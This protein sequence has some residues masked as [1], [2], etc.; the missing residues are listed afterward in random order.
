MERTPPKIC[1]PFI[2]SSQ[3]SWYR[4]PNPEIAPADSRTLELCRGLSRLSRRTRQIFLLSRADGMAYADI[5]SF[6]EIDLRQVEHAMV[7]ALLQCGDKTADI[8]AA[9]GWYVHLQSPQATPSQRIEFRHWL[10]AAPEN[11]RAFEA[12]E[13]LWRKLLPAAEHLASSRW[14]QRKRRAYI[15]WYL[16]TAFVCSLLVTAEAFSLSF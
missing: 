14:Y 9:V 7:K 10:D 1:E 15:G 11:L 6:L 4:L 2:M 5:A 12:T 13:Q 8:Q 3:L 16:L